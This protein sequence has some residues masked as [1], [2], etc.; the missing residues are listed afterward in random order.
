MTTTKAPCITEGL[1]ALV[2]ILRMA[3]VIHIVGLS[4]AT[5][6]RLIAQGDFSATDESYQP[7]RRVVACRHF[8]L[9]G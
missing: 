4:R 3:E 7:I 9:A 6:Y 5:I 1:P 8:S 2:R